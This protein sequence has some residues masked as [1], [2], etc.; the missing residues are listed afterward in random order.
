[1]DAI[2]S[3]QS[4]GFWGYRFKLCLCVRPLP[5][6]YFTY[7]SICHLGVQHLLVN[8]FPTSPKIGCL[9]AI[10]L[11]FSSFKLYR[12][13]CTACYS[14]TAASKWM[15]FYTQPY[16]GAQQVPINYFSTPLKIGCLAAILLVFFWP[17]KQYISCY[18]EM[19]VSKWMLFNT[20]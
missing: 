4:E 12:D 13:L 2:F 8:Y 10:L 6:G 11:F 18:L 19:A 9:P 16:M 15:I 7:S 14:Y 17:F 5:P 1:M 20:L 3:L